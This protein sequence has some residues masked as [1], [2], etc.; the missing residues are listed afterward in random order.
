MTAACTLW[1]LLYIILYQIDFVMVDGRSIFGIVDLEEE[2]EG[3]GGRRRREVR[4]ADERKEERRKE[5]VDTEYC[6]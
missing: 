6:T 2:E 5:R 1:T 4:R 3:K